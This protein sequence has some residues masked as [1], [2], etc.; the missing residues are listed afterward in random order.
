M[1]HNSPI[2]II[3]GPTASGKSSFAIHLAKLING[4]IINFDSMQVYKDLKILTA[5]PN[6]NDLEMVPHKL[7]GVIPGNIRCTAIYW[8]NLAL[9][10]ID[11]IQKLGRV[12]IFVGGTGLYIKT[13]IDGISDVPKSMPKYK[14][15]ADGLLRDIGTQNFYNVVKKKDPNI[16]KNISLNDHQRLVRAYT[17]WLQTNIPLSEWH[18]KESF[19]KKKNNIYV[20]IRIKPNRKI[21]RDNIKKRFINMINLGVI[22]EVKNFRQFNSTLPIMKAHGLREIIAY[23]EGKKKLDEVINE[24]TNNINQYAKR[25]DTWF[26]NKYLSDYDILDANKNIRGNCTNILSLYREMYT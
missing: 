9:K 19:N 22:E 5:R 2:I 11:V 6:K 1:K 23:I 13:L 25:Q 20:K 21:L 18:K 12:P 17:V 26:K 7:Y 15:K 4:S 24:T 8:R 10:E 3:A 14:R 16:V